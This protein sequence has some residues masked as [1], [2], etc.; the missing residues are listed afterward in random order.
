[1]TPQDLRAWRD[2]MEYTQAKAAL[3]LGLS[4]DGYKKLELGVTKPRDLRT[5]LACAALAKGLQPWSTPVAQ[6]A[7]SAPQ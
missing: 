1:M 5:D 7:K 2:Q 4:L 6:R 3:A